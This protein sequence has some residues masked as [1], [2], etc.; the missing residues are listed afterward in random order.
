M[1]DQKIL[2]ELINEFTAITRDYT[3]NKMTFNH[4]FTWLSQFEED[5][6]LILMREMTH[7]V[8]AHYWS[9]GMIEE[10]M[11]QFVESA[12]L[13]KT[14]FSVLDIQ[15]GRG[16]S[17]V[18]INSLF[19]LILARDFFLH[20][21]PTND[22]NLDILLYLDDASFTGARLYHSLSEFIRKE[23]IKIKKLLSL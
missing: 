2:S 1:S 8:K 16:S 21:I 19:N 15:Q 13:H 7:I 4:V 3:N 23:E 5:N 10:S 22:Y 6:R 11:R 9:V 20:N 12:E 17:Q 14:S 18:E